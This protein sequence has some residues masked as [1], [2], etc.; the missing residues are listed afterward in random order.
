MII[1][2]LF[3]GVGGIIASSVLPSSQA[4]SS[5]VNKTSQVKMIGTYIPEMTHSYR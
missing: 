5:S 4:N 3:G 1:T 2:L